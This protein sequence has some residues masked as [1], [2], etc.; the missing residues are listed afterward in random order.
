MAKIKR[1]TKADGGY[2]GE[3][4][5]MCPGCKCMHFINDNL[6]EIPGLSDNHIWTFNGNFDKPTIRASVLQWR[7]DYNQKTENYDIMID[8][9]HS[10]ITDGKI[11]F[12][13]DSMHALA[14]QTVEMEDII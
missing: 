11:E 7:Y 3:L 9:C 2:H 1:Y 13:S 5:F 14:G 4:G 6:T 8:R 12:L 10:F